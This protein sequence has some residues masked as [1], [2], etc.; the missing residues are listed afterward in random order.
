MIG[1]VDYGSGNLRSVLNALGHVG[2]AFTVVSKPEEVSGLDAI[3]LPGVGAFGDA[4]ANLRQTNLIPA[5]DQAVLREGMPFLGICLGMQLIFERSL[6]HGENVGLGWVKGT[7]ER[8][9][10]HGGT[11]RV[12]HMG[13][14]TVR[15]QR[16]GA[17]VL[18]GLGAEQ[19]FYFVH[20]FRCVPA[21]RSVILGTCEH[22]GEV[23]AMVQTGNITAFQFHPEKSLAAGLRLLENWVNGVENRHG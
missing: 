7:V 20:S 5:L 10:D 22:G 6:E 1:V 19:D 13:W 11:V 16:P 9:P 15:F 14:N 4:M 18:D 21:D 8:I 23:T 12:P 3:I 17:G 2:A